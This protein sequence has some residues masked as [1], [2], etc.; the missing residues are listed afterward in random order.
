MVDTLV[1]MF[2][3]ALFLHILRDGRKVVHSMNNFCGLLSE[4]LRAEFIKTARLPAWAT[5]FRLA[6]QTWRRFVD[7]SMDFCARHPDRCLTIRNEDL[8]A[9][10]EKRFGDIFRF[11]GVASEEGP[12]A[13]FRSHRINTSFPHLDP[14]K[15]PA[16]QSRPDPWQQWT[17]EQ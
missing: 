14:D 5:N 6:C 9:D 7:V 13:H 15:P 8:V 4:E 16:L 12:A 11:L 2:P 10:T 3:G 17:T 1:E